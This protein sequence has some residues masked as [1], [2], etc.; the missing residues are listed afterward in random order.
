VDQSYTFTDLEKLFAD[1]EKD[2]REVL[3][4]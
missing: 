2:V 3:I 1:L 4:K